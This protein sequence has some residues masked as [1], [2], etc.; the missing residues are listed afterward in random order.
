MIVAE[1]R[2]SYA[3]GLFRT[4]GSVIMGVPLNI[5]PVGMKY[6]LVALFAGKFVSLLGV[7]P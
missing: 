6:V 3:Q 7:C 1:S 5:F 2:V 4:V